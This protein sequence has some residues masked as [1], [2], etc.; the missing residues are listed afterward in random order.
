MSASSELTSCHTTVAS[1]SI[2][3]LKWS[4]VTN[5]G[6]TG[7]Q[8]AVG[9]V[10]ARLLDPNS[11]GLVALGWL[12]IA[13]GKLV[14][15]AGFAAALVQRE[16]VATEDV[17][18]VFLVQ[19]GIAAAFTLTAHAFSRA[20]GEFFSHPEAAE[21]I[22]AMSWIFVLQAIAQPFASVLSR[23]LRFGVIQLASFT[24]YLIGYTAVGVP[25]AYAGWGVWSLVLAQVTQSCLYA[26]WMVLASDIALRVSL[27]PRSAGLFTFGKKVIGANLTSWV[28][29]NQDTLIIGKVV[30]VVNLGVYNRTLSLVTTI[31]TAVT[32]ALQPI[33]FSACSRVQRDPVRVRAAFIGSTQLVGY[34]CLPPL[35]TMAVVPETVVVGLY[36]SKWSSAVPVLPPL[37]L[38]MAVHALL[39]MIGPVL[40]AVDRVRSEMLAQLAVIA[41]SIP[42]LLLASRV[43]LSTVAWVVLATFV[44]RW[45]LLLRALVGAIGLR[46]RTALGSLKNPC[47]I[48]CAAAGTSFMV[49][50]AFGHPHGPL[51]LAAVV[52]SALA[53]ILASTRLLGTR[54]LEGPIQQFVAERGH[55]PGPLAF[56]LKYPNAIASRS[57]HLSK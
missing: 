33:L 2:G 55:L 5:A 52:L 23:G 16:S 35:L 34:L 20:I 44:A 28:I 26:L 14:A 53:G 6:R 27:R 46:W 38:A 30:G 8:F 54:L 42:L 19:V 24:T 11:F 41:I 13:A 17:S 43:S 25:L 31:S 57:D 7:V 12:I 4:Y 21:V 37:A 18:F 9:V 40:T 56:W 49:D 36:S 32:A 39:A 10:L 48:A 51:R 50:S 22:S 3:S 47:Y 29:T 15:D 1:Q 45:V